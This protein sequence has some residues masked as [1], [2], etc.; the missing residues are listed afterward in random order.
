[1]YFGQLFYGYALNCHL[2]YLIIPETGP[3]SMIKQDFF[4][5]YMQPQKFK[6]TSVQINMKQVSYVIKGNKED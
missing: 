4:F 1:M 2:F 6:L 3:L 5:I